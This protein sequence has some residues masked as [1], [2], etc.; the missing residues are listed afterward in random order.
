[1]RCRAL[2]PAPERLGSRP[3][4]WRETGGPQSATPMTRNA[5]MRRG[6]WPPA[7]PTFNSSATRQSTAILANPASWGVSFSSWPRLNRSRPFCCNSDVGLGDGQ[8][9]QRQYRPPLRMKDWVAYYDS[10]HS[11]YV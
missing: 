1:M 11:I 5:R 10:E 4:G 8:M 6:N 7:N 9:P 2:E 3:N